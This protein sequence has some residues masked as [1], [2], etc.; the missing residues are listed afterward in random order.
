MRGREGR[1]R[2][3]KGRAAP[4]GVAAALGKGWAAGGLSLPLPAPLGAGPGRA[5]LCRAGP[6]PPGSARR[7]CGK[8]ARLG[9]GGRD[10]AVG[11]QPVPP[12]LGHLLRVEEPLPVPPG[13][14]QGSSPPALPWARRGWGALPG[15]FRPGRALG[16]QSLAPSSFLAAAF[17]TSVRTNP[18]LFCGFFLV[19][20]CLKLWWA[21]PCAGSLC[22]ACV[23][24]WCLLR[25]P[26][27]E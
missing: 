11:L 18:G 15:G 8:R 23:L 20:T 10:G 16:T 9:S 1:G 12:A 25:C 22:C 13:G 19:N 2:E 26:S 27:E 7:C 4:R 17:L 6:P 14:C 5:V 21:Q 3:G 24:L